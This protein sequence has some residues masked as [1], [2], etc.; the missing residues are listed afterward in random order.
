MIYILYCS[1]D[2]GTI[3][4]HRGCWSVIDKAA[5]DVMTND[6]CDY[7]IE[8]F[9]EQGAVFGEDR[10]RARWLIFDDDDDAIIFKLRHG[11]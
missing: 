9:A 8:W 11:V 6:G 7:Y 10:D 1:Y 3:E 4:E 5:P 2:N